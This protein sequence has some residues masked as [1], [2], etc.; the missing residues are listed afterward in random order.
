MSKITIQVSLCNG[1]PFLSLI[2]AGAD[3]YCYCNHPKNKEKV[4][5]GCYSLRQRIDSPKT[6]ELRLHPV[7]VSFSSKES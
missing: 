5:L 7:V 3:N 6:C 1:C 2:N 4:L